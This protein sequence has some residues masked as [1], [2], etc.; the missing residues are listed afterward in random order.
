MNND[1]FLEISNEGAKTEKSFTNT[2]E[3]IIKLT[4]Q[5][6]DGNKKEKT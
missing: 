4:K 2:N 3:K 1:L 6:E 5:M